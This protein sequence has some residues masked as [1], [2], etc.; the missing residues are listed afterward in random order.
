MYDEAF[1]KSNT[2]QSQRK[3]KRHDSAGTLI[4]KNNQSTI[5]FPL[6]SLF[7]SKPRIKMVSV[8]FVNHETPSTTS[9][10]IQ[11]Q[12]TPTNPTTKPA[13]SKVLASTE[14]SKTNTVE[15]TEKKS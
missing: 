10:I 13:L 5:S 12:P 8:P 11:I 2:E 6:S 9:D 15:E 4:S 1:V 7:R 14:A 3:K